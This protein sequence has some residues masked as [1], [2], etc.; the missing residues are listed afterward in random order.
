MTRLA[1]SQSPVISVICVVHID[2]CHSTHSLIKTGAVEIYKLP[3]RPG[4]G[5]K[6]RKIPLI[7]NYFKVDIPEDLTLYQYDVVIEPD[8]P[9]PV[10]R[11]VMKKAVEDHRQ[12]FSGQ[13]PVFDGEKGLY[14]HKEL[15]IRQA[16]H[17]RYLP[18]CYCN[19]YNVYNNVLCINIMTCRLRL[20]SL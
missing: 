9:K 3:P 6:G 20:K 16:C 13:F 10:K 8:V 12:E 19:V 2:T 5:T 1:L 15:R 4:Y 17:H 11:R 18:N 14:C 7:T